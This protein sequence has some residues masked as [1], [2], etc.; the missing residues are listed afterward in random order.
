MRN[1]SLIGDYNMI[2]QP[3]LN[4]TEIDISSQILEN[5]T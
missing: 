5:Y 1:C 3:I 4:I 2:K